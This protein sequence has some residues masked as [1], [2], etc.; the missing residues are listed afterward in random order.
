MTEGVPLSV[1]IGNDNTIVNHLPPEHRAAVLR[2]KLLEWDDLVTKTR[3]APTSPAAL[4]DA[5]RAVVPFRGRAE[6]LAE[7]RAWCEAPGL[8]IQL[9]YGPGGQGKTR[10]ARRLVDR[11]GET[12]GDEPWSVLWLSRDAPAGELPVLQYTQS[13]LLV[14]VDNAE[15]RTDQLPTLLRAA[16][17]APRTVRVKVLLLARTD[18][19]WWY[20]LPAATEREELYDA[21]VTPLRPLE[22]DPDRHA[23]AYRDAVESLARALPRVP[24]QRLVKWGHHVGRLTRPAAYRIPAPDMDVALTLHMTALVDLLDAAHKRGE[25]ASRSRPMEERLLDY[26][27]RYWIAVEADLGLRRRRGI[28]AVLAAALL[29]GAA[30]REEAD[31][32]LGRVP[33]LHGQTTDVRWAVCDWISAL[34]PPP[35]PSQFWGT[36]RPDRLAEYFLGS[37][38]R[39]DP[40]LADRLLAGASEAQ[41]AR[42][43]V[44]HTRAAAHP[45]HREHLDAQL[46][47]LCCRHP[48]VLGALAVD[49]ATQVE[50]PEPLVSALYRLTDDP[51]TD[52]ADLMRLLDRLPSSSHNLAPWALHLTERLTDIHRERAETDSAYLPALARLLRTLCRRHLDMGHR[53]RA[54]EVTEEAVGRLRPLVETDAP[55]FRPHLAASLHNLSIGLGVVGRRA[56]AVA[57]AYEAVGLYR[58]LIAESASPSDTRVYRSELAHALNAVANCE[59]ELGRPDKA[60]TAIEETVG[61]RRAL[62]GERRE[63]AEMADGLN[64]L[65]IWQ[66]E[67]GRH[68][69]A[70]VSSRE[71]VEHYRSLAEE[72][73][74]AFRKGF[75]MSLGTYSNCLRDAG[76]YAEA[77]RVAEEALDIR[78]HL[79]RARPDAYLPD[80]A[81][82]LNS[83]AIDAGETGRRRESV[84]A[85][86]ESVNLYRRLYE[87]EPAA[88]AERLAMSLNTHANQLNDV[89]AQEEAL[90]AARESVALY[91]SLEQ[92]SPGVFPGDLAMGLTTYAGQLEAAGQV[93]E[94]L[95]AA[96]EAVALHRLAAEERPEVFL[97]ALVTG[98]NNLAHQLSSAGA[99]EEALATAEE[100]VVVARRLSAA[101]GTPPA[102]SAVAT[103]LATRASRRYT[104][105]R[106]TEAVADAREARALFYELVRGDRAED[107]APHVPQLGQTLLLLGVVLPEVGLQDEALEALAES[108]GLFR[109]LVEDS[110]EV[111]ALHTPQLSAA[112]T[113]LGKRLSAARRYEEAADAL[114]EAVPLRRKTAGKDPASHPAEFVVLLA[115]TVQLLVT[116]GRRS[117]A[118]PLAVEAVGLLDG[119]LRDAPT[120]QG[121]LGP[122]L[123]LLGLLQHGAGS[124]EADRTLRRGVEVAEDLARTEP[125]YEPVLQMA[126]HGLG[127]YL[128]DRRRYEEGRALL[129]RATDMARRLAAADAAY[130]SALA[131]TL[132][133]LGH[134]PAEDEAPLPD[135]LDTTEEAVTLARRLARADPAVHEPLLAWALAVHGLRLAEA[136]RYDEAVRTAVEAVTVA[137]RAAHQAHLLGFA[138]YASATIRLLENAEPERAAQE[139]ITEALA[140][141][142][143]LAREEPGLVAVHLK[144]AE[145][146]RRGLFRA[147]RP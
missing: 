26:E 46:T 113:Q 120:R 134:Y 39:A 57:P 85:S 6:E 124:E 66:K 50:R 9:V 122:L 30:D 115:T 18:G 41:A 4:L 51:G 23:E 70:L 74:D 94:A 43:L 11:L 145:K 104:A 42:L 55:T 53:Q 141:Y 71:S 111:T 54:Y 117:Q 123:P 142:R 1:Q 119:P 48:E 100:G 103:M 69:E 5:H 68:K 72:H 138:L 109:R 22:P 47:D 35:A 139:D 130:D 15:T 79:A 129:V 82:A 8:G 19:D 133:S 118:L 101:D 52:L 105:G 106:P 89:G 107:A 59:G 17:A 76:R 127:T 116:V 64:N 102:L 78:R 99:Y 21:P 126:V 25:G 16:A 38:L 88:F 136:T 137:R 31:A 40:G 67:C 147:P 20:D 81:R 63:R 32:L 83:F 33:V 84:A 87:R 28:D 146:T 34:Y 135:A 132:A 97:Q 29:C 49:V 108:A 125:A 144:A 131:W 80:L 75:A 13:P 14:V 92:A 128:V 110:Q 2:R 90:N 86:A 37:H 62:V 60:L 45:A 95:G 3:S 44:L 61:I 91:R 143:G 140:I 36:L 10:L 114:L 65:S 77:V 56:D 7:L 93:Q 12:P 73:P 96:R 98:L 27:R 24:G 121:M 58:E 112:L